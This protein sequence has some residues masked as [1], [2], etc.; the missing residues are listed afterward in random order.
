VQAIQLGARLGLGAELEIELLSIIAVSTHAGSDVSSEERRDL[1]HAAAAAVTA[2]ADLRS[3]AAQHSVHKCLRHPDDRVRAN[4]IDAMTR[5]ARRAG[6]I[7]AIESTLA[8]AAIEFKDD[9]HHRVRAAA[10]RARLLGSLR[11]DSSTMSA[12]IAETLQPLLVDT[13]PMHRVSG[14]WLAERAAGLGNQQARDRSDVAA[15]V[16]EVVRTDPV[17]QVKIRARMTAVRLLAGMT[18]ESPAGV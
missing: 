5:T 7:A 12:P 6:S 16:A 15:L 3:P 1:L 18:P 11:T 2:L 10:V 17:L 14:L 8:H 9:P 4:A 13:R